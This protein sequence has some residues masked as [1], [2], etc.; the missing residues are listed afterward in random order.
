MLFHQTYNKTY[1]ELSR[2]ETVAAMAADYNLS[3]CAITGGSE[4]IWTITEARLG[5]VEVPQVD[6]VDTLGAGDVLHGAYVFHRY[7]GR[8]SV[9]DALGEA[10]AVATSSCEHRGV[11]N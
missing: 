11:R 1:Q 5:R 4:P 6:V 7:A 10:V 2:Q 3:L 8:M 9:L